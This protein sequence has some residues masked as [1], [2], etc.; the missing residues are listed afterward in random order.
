M[1]KSGARGWIEISWSIAVQEDIV[2]S[3]SPEDLESRV[4]P[5]DAGEG[6]GQTWSARFPA[7]LD[8][9]EGHV[10]EV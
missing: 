7:R 4:G 3:T 8:W 5:F 1:G 6:I 9:R 10:K 2:R